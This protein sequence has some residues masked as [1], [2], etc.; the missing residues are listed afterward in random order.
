M[1]DFTKKIIGALSIL[2]MMN[3]AQAQNELDIIGNWTVDSTYATVTFLLTQE[4]IDELMMMVEW[5]AI[6]AEDFMD[7]MGFPLPT[8]QEEWNAIAKNG[9]T[10]SIPDDELDISGFSFNENQMGLFAQGWIPLNYSFSSDSTISFESIE[11]FPF[12][13][14]TIVSATNDNLIMSSSS[15]IIEEDGEFNY[16]IIFYC[17]IAEEFTLGCTEPSALNYNANANIDDG[18]CEYP[19]PCTSNE[20][21]L[22][23]EDEASDGDGRS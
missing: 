10:M 16:N 14:F 11:D 2:F 23:L 9:I 4:E 7:M 13:E 17:S 18:S 15:T 21:L 12:T 19:Y 1:K 20:L 3:S 22:T 6:S 5:G 8:S